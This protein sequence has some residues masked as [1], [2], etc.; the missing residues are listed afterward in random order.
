MNTRVKIL[1]LA[2][3]ALI[4]GAVLTFFLINEDDAEVSQN[5][6]QDVSQDA[7]QD[8]QDQTTE[9]EAATGEEGVTEEEAEE[10]ATPPK[11][12]VVAKV[13]EAPEVYTAAGHVQ[14]EPLPD[15]ATTTTTCTTEQNIECY[16][17]FTSGDQVFE[18]DAKTTDDDGVAIWRWTVG[19]DV[20]SGTWRVVSHAG[21][22]S[23]N[24]ET[25]YVE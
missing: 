4:A 2:L 21:G 20:P 11:K 15:G 16:V 9:E 25:I 5:D 12:D 18:F 8:E 3:A 17:T 23:S 19:N 24:V 13:D 7:T 10:D 6:T 22:K 1:I 14:E